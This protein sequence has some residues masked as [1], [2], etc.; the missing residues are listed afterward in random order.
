LIVIET[1]DLARGVFDDGLAKGDLSVAGEHGAIAVTHG[2]NGR[3]V[4]HLASVSPER[5]SA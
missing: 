2:K 4:D 5:L 3:G 1:T